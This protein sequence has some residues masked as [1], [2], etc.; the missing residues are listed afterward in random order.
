M[1]IADP[2]FLGANAVAAA[3]QFPALNALAYNPLWVIIPTADRWRQ[4]EIGR[5]T[6]TCVFCGWRLVNPDTPNIRALFSI[7]SNVSGKANYINYCHYACSSSHFFDYNQCRYN[8]LVCIHH[9]A[10][11]TWRVSISNGHQEPA[12]NQGRAA[13]TWVE[14]VDLM[15][16]IRSSGQINSLRINWDAVLP[17]F[18]ILNCTGKSKRQCTKKWKNEREHRNLY[19]AAAHQV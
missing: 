17:F 12:Y 14:T 5:L 6:G 11:L 1:N 19:F 4:T 9:P 18:T 10:V 16:S 3:V 2:M 7:T 13:W 15:M 8:A